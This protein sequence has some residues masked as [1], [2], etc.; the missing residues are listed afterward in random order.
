MQNAFHDADVK[1]GL[2]QEIDALPAAPQNMGILEQ[3]RGY[4]RGLLNIHF[5]PAWTFA[6]TTVL[7]MTAGGLGYQYGQRG[8]PLDFGYSAPSEEQQNNG[9]L[10]TQTQT[11]LSLPQQSDELRLRGGPAGE[12]D[13]I[14]PQF[15][16]EIIRNRLNRLI[17][18]VENSDEPARE[19][20]LLLLRTL[21]QELGV[22][23]SE[24]QSDR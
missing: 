13:L 21:V 9:Q 15:D 20:L 4:L 17:E 7:M 23:L 3:A 6:V 5:E 16:E 19:E 1:D 8:N 2:Q 10:Q 24:Q 18:L 14:A 12:Q 22:D 11:E